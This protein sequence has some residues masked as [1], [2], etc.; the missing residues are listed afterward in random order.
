MLI[1][2]NKLYNFIYKHYYNYFN[3]YHLGNNIILYYLQ[4]KFF[5]FV[6]VQLQTRL[7]PGLRLQKKKNLIRFKFR[8]HPIPVIDSSA[9]Y[10]SAEGPTWPSMQH[11]KCAC[12]RAVSYI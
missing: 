11:N 12:R 9:I 7:R 5:F 3:H 8:I 2:Y 1:I 4:K 10:P 6:Y